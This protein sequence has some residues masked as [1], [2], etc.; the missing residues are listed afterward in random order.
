MKSMQ[1]N[2]IS[3]GVVKTGGY[4]H[5]KCLFDAL[6]AYKSGS[7]EV[8]GRLI[9]RARLFKSLIGYLDLI[10]WS[11]F[12]SNADI[13]IVTAR[14]GLSAILRNWFT[15]NEVWIVLH[16]Y[17]ENDGKTERMAFYYQLLFSW[18]KKAKHQ[19]FKII[20]GAPYWVKYFE[21]QQ[22][23]KN[24]YLFPNFF[25]TKLYTP[26][27]KVKKDQSV[28]MG[29]WSSKNDP[30]IIGLADRLSQLGYYCYFSTLYAEDVQSF[31]GSYE[32]ICFESQATFLEQMSRATCTLALIRLNEGWNRIAHESLLVGTPVVGFK[33]GGL[34]DLLKESN[35]VIVNSIEEAYNCI[36]GG[37]WVL[38]DHDFFE[39]YN[40]SNTSNYLEVLCSSHSSQF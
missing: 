1:I 9:R 32:I 6:C 10:L 21:Q 7:N 12:K 15:K 37:V 5:E 38:P 20:T 18:L 31:N 23:L 22:G 16:N 35:S 13:N 4:R 40:L 29:Q 8:K 19:R 36:E 17:D 39:K 25:D 2:Y 26:Y 3:Y 24:S 30:Q 14:T 27:R 11:Y 28:F 33:R 34:G